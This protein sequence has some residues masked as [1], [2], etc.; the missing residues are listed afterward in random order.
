MFQLLS[1]QILRITE[2]DHYDF[3]LISDYLIN[4]GNCSNVLLTE[5]EHL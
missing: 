2:D 3:I 1:S 4:S 5:T